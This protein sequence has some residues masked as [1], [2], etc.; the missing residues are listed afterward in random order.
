MKNTL[1]AEFTTH[2]ATKTTTVAYQFA[3]EVLQDG[4][5]PLVFWSKTQAGAA[6]LAARCVDQA[7]GDDDIARAIRA[8]NRRTGAVVAVQG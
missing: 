7:L 8:L 5:E 1:T 4:A 3:A 2:T 6:K